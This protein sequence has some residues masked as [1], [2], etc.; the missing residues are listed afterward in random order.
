MRSNALP[1][2]TTERGSPT[3][4]TYGATC[5]TEGNAVTLYVTGIEI[6]FVKPAP[7]YVRSTFA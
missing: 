1:R 4:A 6:W 5:S 3:T 7:L 2:M